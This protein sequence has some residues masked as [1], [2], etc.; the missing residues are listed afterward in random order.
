M[1]EITAVRGKIFHDRDEKT[2]SDDSLSVAPLSTRE[3]MSRMVRDHLLP[4]KGYLALSFLAM[5]G[6]AASTGALPFLMQYTSD[7]IV[8]TKNMASLYVMP[9]LVVLVIAVKAISEY[10]SSVSE[11]YIGQRITADLRAR[12]FNALM[13]ADLAWIQRTHSGRFTS[14]FLGDVGAIQAAA[15][16]SIVGLGKNL[17]KCVFLI[18]GMF[19]MDWILTLA[20]AIG[21]PFAFRQIGRQSRKMMRSST[22]VFQEHGDLTSFVTQALNGIRV[23]KAYG[24]EE[25]ETARVRDV[26]D[27]TVEFAMQAV[28][29][30]AASG[31]I[32]ETLAGVGIAAAIF[33]G[34]YRGITGSMTP[35]E[36]MGFITAAMLLYQPL[37]GLA[38]LQTTLQLGVV[39]ASRVFAIIDRI[40]EISDRGGAAPLRVSNG[41]IAFD[42]VSFG[43]DA[44][45]PVLRDF[46]LDIPAKQKVALVGPSGAGK[47]T[48]LNLILRFY[49]PQGGTVSIDG[50]DLKAAQVGSVRAASALVTQDPFL[51]DDTIAANIS[52]GS[53]AA[54][55]ED[56]EAA[57]RA[58]V[59]HDFIMAMPDGYETRVGEAGNR[60]SGGQKQRISFARAMLRNAPILLLDE[61]TS[62]LDSEAEALLQEA[63]DRL[64]NDRTVI[65]I[66]HRLSTV[67]R[68]DVICVM[69]EGRIVE[70]GTHEELLARGGLYARLYETQLGEVDS[71]T[72]SASGRRA[73][74]RA[75][76]K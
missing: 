34:G 19:Y 73:R 54:T 37:K 35:G 40:P 26:I 62:A 14:S 31:P 2:R 21:L 70:S 1:N 22:R 28:R 16:V 20:A 33:Y 61:P 52:Y 56:I 5:A 27:R 65:M 71:D 13:H 60:L 51:F 53:E 44:D 17:L 7:E 4:M 18:G 76:S 29:V 55:R 41:A 3:V 10:I 49:E 46:S 8:V 74:R 23:V 63:L 42:N 36:F 25:E 58:A 39:A 6:V 68:A 69:D 24:R 67:K 59:A 64:V 57:A 12:M 72:A 66:A 9:P 48:V 15:G 45:T 11:E 38:T 50:Q 43:Y 47:S 75:A 32:T 30:R